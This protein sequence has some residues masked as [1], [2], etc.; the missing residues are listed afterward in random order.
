MTRIYTPM[1]A[2]VQGWYRTRKFGF[3][4]GWNSKKTKTFWE[5]HKPA[6]TTVIWQKCA[7]LGGNPFVTVSCISLSRAACALNLCLT[8]SQLLQ[9]DHPMHRLQHIK[10]GKDPDECLA[11]SATVTRLKL[12]SFTPFSGEEHFAACFAIPVIILYQLKLSLLITL[13]LVH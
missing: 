9:W 7:G 6:E 2:K 12:C 10:L 13:L 8:S 4:G 3:F 5:W 11:N 1:T